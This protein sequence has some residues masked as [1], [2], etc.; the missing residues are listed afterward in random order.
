MTATTEAAPAA[1]ETKAPSPYRA[2][3]VT[4]PA[5]KDFKWTHIDKESW[6]SVV[7]RITDVDAL[8]AYDDA[9]LEV[10]MAAAIPAPAASPTVPSA[11]KPVAGGI[12]RPNG[13]VYIPRVIKVNGGE[14]TQD[15]PLV[16][17]AYDNKIP[18]L[19][20]GP[21]GT[22]KTALAEASLGEI[23]TLSCTADT[24]VADFIGSWV[25][26]APGSDREY[27]WVDGP[28]PYAMENGLPFLIDEIALAD[29][30]V[31]AAVYS[32]M[33]GR[34]EIHITANPARGTVKAAPGFYIIGACNPNV[35]G[36]V[37]SDALLSRF[38][39]QVEVLTD[40]GLAKKMGVSSEIV[41]VAKTLARRFNNGD[42]SKSPQMRELLAFK[43]VSEVFGLGIALSNVISSADEGD[44]DVYAEVITRTYGTSFDTLRIGRL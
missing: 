20:Y 18:V 38:Q 27:E 34:D 17:T 10:T 42:I 19:L 31:L 15:V 13:E 1:E 44:R 43:R 29:T 6:S 35:P 30:K 14:D 3:K 2:P 32:V 16:Q 11:R 22:G 37:M 33:D 41:T 26:A 36:A 7:K 8:T 24:E 21:P 25:Q 39:L 5:D 4:F 9:A 40:F 12:T 28:L 23:V